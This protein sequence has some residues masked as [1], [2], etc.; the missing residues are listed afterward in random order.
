MNLLTFSSTIIHTLEGKGE[1][2]TGRGLSHMRGYVFEYLNEN[3]YNSKERTPRKYN[4]LAHKK[5]I[6]ELDIIRNIHK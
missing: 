3:N 4:K 6:F 2:L 1:L 5:L